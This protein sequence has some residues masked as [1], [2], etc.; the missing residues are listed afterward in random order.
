MRAS[1]IPGSRIPHPPGSSRDFPLPAVP[2]S[3]DEVPNWP[4]DP[5]QDISNIRY[6]IMWVGCFIPPERGR[7]KIPDH[8]INYVLT[9]WNLPG[10]CSLRG[11][12]HSFLPDWGGKEKTSLILLPSAEV[13]H[14]S[15][16]TM[17]VPSV[18]RGQ[19]ASCVSDVK[20]TLN[21]NCNEAKW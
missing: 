12:C 3:V 19:R 6:D 8:V 16:L 7:G 10:S 21:L 17:A 13:G 5:V 9:S 2:G 1:Q 14:V 15:P 20:R 4:R 18:F 11:W